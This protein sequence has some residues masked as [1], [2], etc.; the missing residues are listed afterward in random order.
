MKSEQIEIWQNLTRHLASE[1]HQTAI[2]KGWWDEPRN[3]GELLALCHSELSEA[4]EALRNGNKA[5][6]KIPT[7]TGA[8]AELA[9][10]IIR[11]L[12]M[13]NA[14]GWDIAGAVVAKM[15]MNKTRSRRHGG[16][17]F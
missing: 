1:I 6:D 14:R 9:D 12:D 17:K 16:K 10:T 4:L 8:E 2:D 13:S 5:D 7:H 11:V 3:D 15:A